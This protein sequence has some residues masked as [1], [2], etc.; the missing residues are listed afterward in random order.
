MAILYSDKYPQ[1]KMWIPEWEKFIRF[2]DGIDETDDEEVAKKIQKRLDANQ[3][4][5]PFR[6]AGKFKPFK[7][8]APVNSP[9]GP[10]VILLNDEGDFIWEPDAVLTTSVAKLQ[11]IIAKIADA[12]VIAQAIAIEEGRD[13][14]TSPRQSVIKMLHERESLL[15]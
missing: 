10:G 8:V 13:D 5:Q 12:S 6:V 9:A 4:T 14:G 7:E 2:V 11:P 3:G 1:V 15:S